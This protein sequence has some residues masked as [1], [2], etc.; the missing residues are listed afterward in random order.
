[1]TPDDTDGRHLWW[2]IPSAIAGVLGIAGATIFRQRRKHASPPAAETQ[3]ALA[4]PPLSPIAATDPDPP[5]R[6]DRPA[7]E[8]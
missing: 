5:S 8:R 1:M 6:A 7:P 4:V 3:P 2:M